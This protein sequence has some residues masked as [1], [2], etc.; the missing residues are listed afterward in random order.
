MCLASL[1]SKKL[2]VFFAAFSCFCFAAMTQMGLSMNELTDTGAVMSYM[3]LAIGLVL[4]AVTAILCVA[5]LLRANR[6]N[7]ALMKAFGYSLKQCVLCV[8]GGYLPFALLGFALGTVYQ[9]GLL[10]LMINVVFAGVESIPSYSFNVPV[11]FMTLAAFLFSYAL[12]TA[13]F[14]RKIGKVPVKEIMLEE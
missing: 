1:K 14:A 10:M 5:A 11:F 13:L 4:A 2:L 9:Y 12:L 7:I 6:K 8:L 3:I